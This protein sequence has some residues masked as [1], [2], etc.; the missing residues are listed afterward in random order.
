[1]KTISQKNWLFQ[2]NP[3]IYD[4]NT[5]LTENKDYIYWKVS[6]HKNEIQTGDTVFLL[7]CESKRLSGGIIAYGIISENSKSKENVEHIEAM[8][9]DLWQEEGLNKNDY[10]VVGIK[11]Y[12]VRLTPDEGMIS[13]DTIHKNEA[14]AK[15]KILKM[16][17][18]TN[19]LL[20]RNEAEVIMYLW[21]VVNSSQHL[22]PEMETINSREGKLKLATHFLHERNPLLSNK[23]KELFKRKHNGKLFCELCSFSFETTYGDYGKGYIEAH[24]IKPISEMKD[25][26]VTKVTDF[27]MLCAN[28]H[29][30][31]H[32]IDDGWELLKNIL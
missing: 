11:L 28:C 7:R 8:R 19:Y 5:Y 30:M 13:I 10:L 1:M 3:K 2:C 17:R 12:D 16:W 32:R 22:D 20:E 25:G 6:Q 23:A 15:M 21:G 4:V 24:H 26:E 9:N 29:R 14:L 18:H 31:V 27:K